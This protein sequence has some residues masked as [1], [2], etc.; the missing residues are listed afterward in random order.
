MAHESPSSDLGIGVGVLLSVVAVLGAVGM[1]AVDPS[2][3]TA[4]GLHVAAVPF[5]IA[6]VAGVAAVASIHLFWGE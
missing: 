3:T 1:A 5:A 4:S 2:A 6:I